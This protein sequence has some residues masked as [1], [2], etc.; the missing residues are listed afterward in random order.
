MSHMTG[1]I[2]ASDIFLQISHSWRERCEGAQRS[3]PGARRERAQ[4]SGHHK[5]MGRGDIAKMASQ[6]RIQ[7]CTALQAHLP[8]YSIGQL[9][10]ACRLPGKFE[11]FD[12][13]GQ[14]DSGTTRDRAAKLG[15]ATILVGSQCSVCYALAP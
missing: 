3:T 5:L 12:N 10:N 11:L 1:P 2:F 9:S 14:G 7:Y 6:R 13:I 4:M 8:I 15:T